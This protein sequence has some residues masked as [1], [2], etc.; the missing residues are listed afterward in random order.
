MFV[1]RTHTDGQFINSTIS[2]D[3]SSRVPWLHLILENVIDRWVSQIN[4]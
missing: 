3:Y 2:D 4:I 1:T